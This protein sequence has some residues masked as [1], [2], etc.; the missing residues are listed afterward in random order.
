MRL[1]R[2]FAP[3]RAVEL[4]EERVAVEVAFDLGEVQTNGPGQREH[5]DL[6]AADHKHVLQRLSR[7]ERSFD[8]IGRAAAGMTPLARAR[9][10]DI[11]PSR[12]RLSDRIESSSAHHDGVAQ[13]QPPETLQVLRQSPGHLVLASYCLI[14]RDRGDDGDARNGGH[15]KSKRGATIMRTG[16]A[17][18]YRR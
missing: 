11:I 15:W 7:G 9:D 18:L 4:G 8:R 3:S 17:A 12:Q 6:G 5:V 10:D 16:T 2:G 14:A 1:A 13:R